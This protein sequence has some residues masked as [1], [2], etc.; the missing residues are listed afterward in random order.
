MIRHFY[1]IWGLHGIGTLGAA[2]FIVDNNDGGELKRLMKMVGEKDF[3]VILEVTYKTYR[4]IIQV[5]VL[6]N[7]KII[8]AA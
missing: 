8:A 1:Y 5:K 3:C 6:T 7:P 4:E 2:Q